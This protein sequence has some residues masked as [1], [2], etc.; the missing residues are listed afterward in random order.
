MRRIALIFTVFFITIQLF[1]QITVGGQALIFH[2]K[3]PGVDYLVMYNGI[4]NNSSLRYNG[5][6][7][8]INWYKFS[9]IL[10]PITNQE[11]NFNIENATGYILEVDGVRTATVWVMDYTDYLPVFNSLT[12]ALSQDNE[13]E[14]LTLIL[15]A[16]VPEMRYTSQNGISYKI[17]REFKLKYQTKQWSNEWDDKEI[18]LEIVLP[19]NDIYIENPPLCD[20]RFVIEGDQFARDL[21]RTPNRVESDLYYA[22]AVEAHITSVATTRNALNEDLRP[23]LATTLEGSAPLEVFF[24]SNANVPIAQFYR[25]EIFKDNQL[26][27]IRNDQDQRYTFSESGNYTVRLTTSNSKC[28]HVDSVMVKMSDSA[29]EVPLVFTPNGDNINDEFRVAYRS[30]ASFNGWIYNRWGRRVFTWNDPQKGWDGKIN[31]RDA[32][33]GGYV[34]LIEAV[35]TDGKKYKRKGVVN[36]LRGK[37]SD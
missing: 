33:V 10:N 2:K 32:A 23:S 13:C 25:W 29:L 22:Q 17:D 1:A 24:Q 7:N 36:L 18:D 14:G 27:F 4:D 30:L 20:T 31:G 26:L 35:G 21:A 19:D 3:Y 37:K 12:P 15:D 9:D 28:E 11:E 5:T 8:A 34:F 6:Y 16:S